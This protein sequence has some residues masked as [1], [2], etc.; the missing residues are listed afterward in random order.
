MIMARDFRHVEFREMVTQVILKM[1]ARFPERQRDI[2]IWNHYRGYSLRQ[3]A[4]VLRCTP[5]DVEATLD[6]LNLALYQETRA[7]LSGGPKLDV[8]AKFSCSL[9]LKGGCCLFGSSTEPDL[10]SH[11]QA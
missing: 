8:E 11:A 3:I 4:E 5:A 6:T 7:L 9:M 1:L 10:V 2:F